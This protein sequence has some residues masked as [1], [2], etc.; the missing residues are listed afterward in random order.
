MKVAITR[1]V[2]RAVGRCELT[3]LE[4]RPIDLGR[5][6]K[7]H[8]QYEEALAGLGCRVECLPEEPE[9]PDSVFVEDAALVLDELAILT[10]PGAAS[11]R[12]ER[13]SV[14]RALE[15]YRELEAI[16][17]PGTLDGGDILRVGRRIWVGRS[18]RSN[19][20][21][22]RRLAELT[23]P[24]GYELREV[25]VEGCLHLKSAVCAVSQ[26]ILLL[27]P[28]WVDP[29]AFPGFEILEVDPEEPFG[30]NALLVGETILHPAAHA[31]T[32]R[33]LEKRGLD[34]HSVELSELAKAEGGVT[35]CSLLLEAP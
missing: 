27:N 4:R 35:C 2:S 18:S 28:Q 22:R 29:G 14:A 15:R 21:G 3:H 25:P 26:G 8:R 16:E 34:V 32:R 31:G 20:E 9:L 19:G 7:E 33:R 12:P 10:R 23:A 17:A 1:E 5:A 30:A 24:R 13:T 11:R 6:R